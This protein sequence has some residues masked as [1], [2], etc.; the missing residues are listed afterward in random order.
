MMGSAL[1]VLRNQIQ[2]AEP[3]LKRLDLEMERIEFD[4]RIPASVEAARATV[5]SVIDRLMGAFRKNPI[6]GP[7]TDDLKSQYLESIAEQ[8]AEARQQ[9]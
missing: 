4:P 6:L 1:D 5:D 8:V 9:A 2:D 7:L 3:V